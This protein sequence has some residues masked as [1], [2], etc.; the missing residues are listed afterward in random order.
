M[1][2]SADNSSVHSEWCNQLASHLCEKVR[3]TK[4]TGM[5]SAGE[6]SDSESAFAMH[7][8]RGKQAAPKRELKRFIAGDNLFVADRC[9]GVWETP[10]S[11]QCF[12]LD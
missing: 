7:M 6:M 1:T 2:L 9:K 5:G 10:F 3:G 12:Q 8:A 11:H 4:G